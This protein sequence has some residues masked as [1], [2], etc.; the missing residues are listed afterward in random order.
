MVRHP[1]RLC[2][3]GVDV[4][5][6]CRRYAIAGLGWRLS[7]RAASRHNWL[8][9]ARR[10][11]PLGL[12][13]SSRRTPSAASS[14]SRPT[15]WKKWRQWHGSAPCFTFRTGTWRS[16][17]SNADSASWDRLDVI[18]RTDCGRL[19]AALARRF[20]AAHLE[21][22]EDAVQ[23]ALARALERWPAGGVPDRPDAWLVRV[24]YNLALDA[25]RQRSQLT[26]LP[27][28]TRPRLTRSSSASWTTHSR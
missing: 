7:G 1:G 21:P 14:S 16:V 10:S 19:V 18:A 13:R 20:G 4:L 2:S 12:A 27:S 22:I 25:L 24:A 26:E 5:V 3:Y 11:V 28:G 15:R 8:A 23:V 9:T 6:E 17:L